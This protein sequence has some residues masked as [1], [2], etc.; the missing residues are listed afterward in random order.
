[1]ENE[2]IVKFFIGTL[3]GRTVVSVDMK[4]QEFMYERKADAPAF[5]PEEYRTVGFS[6]LRVDLIATIQTDKEIAELK[7]LLNTNK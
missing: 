2:P 7:R 4:L 3:L 1:M 5:A 6:V